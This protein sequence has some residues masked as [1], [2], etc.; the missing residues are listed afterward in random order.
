[1]NETKAGISAEGSFKYLIKFKKLLL[2]FFLS[3]IIQSCKK[4]A[5]NSIENNRL[6]L[7]N[8]PAASGEYSG[9]HISAGK[10][11]MYMTYGFG[12]AFTPFINGLIFN[13]E[14]FGG[15][16]MATD[17]E[18]EEIWKKELPTGLVLTTP[19]EFPDGSCI[20]A[21][22]NIWGYSFTL[23]TTKINFFR[24]DKN[25][26]QILSD[27]LNLASLFGN[28]YTIGNID[29]VQSQNGNILL[30]GTVIFP[31]TEG[32]VLEYNPAGTINW[33]KKLNFRELPG[34]FNATVIEQCTKTKDGGYAFLGLFPGNPDI[35]D[36]VLS[37]AVII[38]TDANC[39]TTWTHLY[40]YFNFQLPYNVPFTSNLIEMPNGGYRFSVS[41][42]T[43]NSFTTIKYRSF[44]YE[45]NA[46]G[47]S[48]KALPIKSSKTIFC[49][50]VINNNKGNTIALTNEFPGFIVP[51]ISSNFTQINT[52]IH[53]FNN[54][55]DLVDS[56]P[57]QLYR[58]DYLKAACKMP[59]GRTA[60][61]GLFSSSNNQSYNPGLLIID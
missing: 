59:D 19:V 35:G 26:N 52:L 42:W 37:K 60:I 47:D 12:S 13:S 14:N 61:F 43:D 7:Y 54:R 32:F 56:A 38:K 17:M 9:I 58:S 8:D 41:E 53:S 16:V 57:L 48:V 28:S 1:M 40:D 29:L 44:I 18:G 39:D 51:A 15:K 22:A 20:V 21:G 49:P 11:R 5:F 27:S 31:S 3:I 25:G 4:E 6:K 46:V 34:G 33:M 2:V 50:L 36:P 55:L 45:V 10:D 30:Y 24:F 23:S